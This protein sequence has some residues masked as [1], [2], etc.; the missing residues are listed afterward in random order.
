MLMKYM[1]GTPVDAGYAKTIAK[2]VHDAAAATEH[3]SE[4]D[5]E[6]YAAET[7]K[8]SETQTIAPALT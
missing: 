7:A 1:D 3:I 5:L 2:L 6:A 4:D 8:K